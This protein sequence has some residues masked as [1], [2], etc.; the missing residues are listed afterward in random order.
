MG[1]RG[2]SQRAAARTRKMRARSYR[3]MRIFIIVILV[4]LAFLAGFVLRGHPHFLQSL[5]LPES[6]T[7]VPEPSTV[8]AS[9]S[10]KDVFNSLSMRVSEVEDILSEDSM[11]TIN[12]DDATVGTMK[13]V[14]DA[15]NDPYLRY[16]TPER[17]AKLLNNND[18]GYAGVGVLFSEYNG[19]AYVVDVFEGSPAQLEGVQI[20]DFVAGVNGDRSQVWSRSEVAAVLSQEQGSTVYIDWR[21]PESLESSGGTEYTTSLSC[22]EY[23]EINVTSEYDEERTVGYVKVKQF[24]QN[25]AALVQA[26][27]DS[28]TAQGARAFVLDLRD[29]PGGYL[30]QAIG[31][32]S[33]FMPGGTVVEVR[34]KDGQSAKPATGQPVSSNPLVVITNKNTAAAAEVVA[35]A[36]KESQRAMVVGTNTMGK[37]SVQIMHDMSFGGA[38]RY[39]AAYYLTPEG[40]AIDQVG[41]TPDVTIDATDEGDFQKDYAM[42]VAGYQ[43]ATEQP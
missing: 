11:D 4:S 28:L 21:R 38:L 36:L 18:E 13:A 31:L 30:G 16:Y 3:L 34:T 9:S 35:A 32:A 23:S 26:E 10:K 1:E 7:G 19:Q 5:G 33:L 22:E 24:T 17:Y 40:H 2:N 25:A 27:I 29:N 14:G 20:G 15:S 42:E 43:A 12:V 39:T 37:G 6:I 41:V 8:D